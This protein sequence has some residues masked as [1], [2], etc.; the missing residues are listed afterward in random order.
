MARI[1]GK[2]E[3]LK[4]LKSELE[5]NGISRFNSVKGIN[6]FLSN[7]NSERLVILNNASDKLE[8]EY[9]ERS[10]NLKQRIQDKSE[11]IILETKKIDNQISVL[12]TKIDSITSIEIL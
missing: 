4:S 10:T 2:I 12:Q 6:D 1:I 3:S 5:K 11:Q 7:Y 8:K 9:F